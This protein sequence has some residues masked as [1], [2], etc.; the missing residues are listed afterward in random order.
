MRN[1]KSATILIVCLISLGILILVSQKSRGWV[2]EAQ[3]EWTVSSEGK[4]AKKIF[5]TRNGRISFPT[6]IRS[7]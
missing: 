4:D 3:E 2:T 7:Q 5:S 1:K 6:F